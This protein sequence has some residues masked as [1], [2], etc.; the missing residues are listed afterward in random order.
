MIRD[1]EANEMKE[2]FNVYRFVVALFCQ[3]FESTHIFSV[4]E[5]REM[6]EMSP[7]TGDRV[8]YYVKD[9]IAND[10]SVKTTLRYNCDA[11][12]DAPDMRFETGGIIENV[13]NTVVKEFHAD[14]FNNSVGYVPKNSPKKLMKEY[15]IY[16]KSTDKDDYED[17]GY[18]H[19]YKGHHD[20]KKSAIVNIFVM[21]DCLMPR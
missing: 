3:V 8:R 21:T 19:L 2:I 1:A 12:G 4:N 16:D 11:G 20:C 13:Y 5:W 17:R 15:V 14:L 18:K 10:D 6:H 9:W 7:K